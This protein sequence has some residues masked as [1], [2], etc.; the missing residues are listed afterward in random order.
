MPDIISKL[1]Q[2]RKNKTISFSKNYYKSEDN[3]TIMGETS[4]KEI[5]FLDYR[6]TEAGSNPREYKGL[7]KKTNEKIIKSL[8]KDHKNMFRFL[9]SGI[10]ISIVNPNTKKTNA[11]EYDDCCL[12]NGN[13]TRFIIL[14]S[15]LLKLYSAN[16]SLDGFNIKNFKKYLKDN[17]SDNFEVYSIISALK[18]NY[19]NQ[20]V[21]FFNSNQKYKNC[22][23]T[24]SLEEFLSAKLRIQLNLINNILEDL[25]DD[26]LDTYGIGTM[27]AEANNDTQNVSADDLFGNKNKEELKGKIFKDFIRKY[28]NDIS[29]EFRAGELPEGTK[30][31][32]ILVL[33]RSIIAAGILTKDKD[34]YKLTNQRTP[35]YTLFQ[36]LLKKDENETIKVISKLIPFLYNI[37]SEFIEPLLKKI[38]EEYIRKYKEKAVN[39][40]LDSTTIAEEARRVQN[41]D[42]E[43]EKLIRRKISYNIEHIVPVVIFKIRDIIKE[44][45]AHN[46]DLTLESNKYKDFFKGLVEAVYNNY[47]KMKLSGV[48]TSFTAD[49]RSE[50]YYQAGDS[51]YIAFKSAYGFDESDYIKNNRKIIK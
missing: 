8:F 23:E 28:N 12:T 39:N 41:S 35:V 17:F 31:V 44:D 24:M 47:I 49:V 9:H 2:I 6:E 32:H 20:F 7:N 34:I 16:E 13:Q 43:L 37:R 3:K 26:S 27:I 11:M 33:L 10:I 5:L 42:A 21:K 40:D 15:V 22:F 50:K 30:K 38:K 4:F 29:I 46:I 1:K 45:S 14:L 48:Q 51:A 18:N 36:K 25:G 19:I